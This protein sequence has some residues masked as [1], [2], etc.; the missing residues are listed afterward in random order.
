MLLSNRWRTVRLWFTFTSVDARSKTQS[1]STRKTGLFP[2]LEKVYFLKDPVMN[3][4]P[5]PAA[6]R[7]PTADRAAPTLGQLM[8]F[9]GWSWLHSWGIKAARVWARACLCP[10][11]STVKIGWYGERQWGGLS[12]QP[13]RGRRISV[14]SRWRAARRLF[15]SLSCICGQ[16]LTGVLRSRALQ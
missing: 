5:L 6:A 2:V 3:S 8:P 14:P 7:S 1:S 10:P 15:S 9:K 12:S 4:S 11:N 13:W 16:S